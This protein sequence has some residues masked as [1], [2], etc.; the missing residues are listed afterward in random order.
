VD[1]V[2]QFSSGTEESDDKTIVVIKRVNEA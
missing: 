2:L 1:D